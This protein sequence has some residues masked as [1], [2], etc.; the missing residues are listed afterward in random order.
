VAAL[1]VAGA[2][3][4][5]LWARPVHG[6]PVSMLLV[7]DACGQARLYPGFGLGRVEVLRRYWLITA[8]AFLAIA[9]LV[10]G[11]KLENVYS[12]LTLAFGFGRSLALMPLLRAPLLR[13]A[14]RRS[15]WAK[16]V[17]VEAG[18]VAYER[19]VRVL[20]SSPAVEFRPAGRIDGGGGDAIYGENLLEEATRQVAR[21][22]R[23]ALADPGVK[24][25]TATLDRL[26][27]VFPR[28]I[29]LRE[30]Q[31]LPVEGVQI[32]NLGGVLGLENGNHLV[33]RQS[34]WVK[35]SLDLALGSVALVL[36]FPIMAAV[37]VLSRGPAL[38]WHDQEGRKG[39]TIRV[40]KIR[41]MVPDAERRME[42]FPVGS[43]VAR[44]VGVGVQAEGR[45]AGH[46][47][48]GPPVLPAIQDRRAGP[49]P[50]RG[51]GRHEP[52]GPASASLLPITS[53]PGRSLDVYIPARTLVAVLSGR[54][55]YIRH[56]ALRP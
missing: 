32:R 54:G 22:E 35:R 9:S 30:I 18:H 25:P 41:T 33:N 31:D 53:V 14:W 42:E 5:L 51:P 8:T 2:V 7:V 44:G 1:L 38:F 17:T 11:L 55:A 34:R 49:V 45:P 26:R 3:A 56:F 20:R 15:W 28:V 40:P 37:K 21:G 52:G 12:R 47:G 10:F 6:Q 4:F 48:G 36:T 13:A 16:P 23:V 19:I 27:L 50:G 24:G 43:G 46:R 39:R 29:V